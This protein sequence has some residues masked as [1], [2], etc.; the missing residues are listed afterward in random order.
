MWILGLKGLIEVGIF[1]SNERISP[2]LIHVLSVSVCLQPLQLKLLINSGHW[3]KI[4]ISLDHIQKGSL[5]NSDLPRLMY[6]AFLF[7]FLYEKIFLGWRM[8][9]LVFFLSCL[10][11]CFSF[12]TSPSLYPSL[13]PLVPLFVL[14]PSSSDALKSI[15]PDYK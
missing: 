3:T 10:L 13:P 1:Y 4:L 7:H 5:Q 11:S 6:E 9:L 12:L 8:F 14:L 15:I 2:V